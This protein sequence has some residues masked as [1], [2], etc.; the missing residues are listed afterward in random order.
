ME[1][2]GRW[3]YWK[4]QFM[5]P[6]FSYG[7]GFWA[8]EEA[9]AKSSDKNI[10]SPLAGFSFDKTNVSIEAAQR[11]QIHTDMNKIIEVGLAGDAAAAVQSLIDQ[12]KAAGVDVIVAEAQKQVDAYMGK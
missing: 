11:D 6:D 5:R 3:A 10:N 1:W 2:G 12:Q 7:P 9:F 4:P 8:E